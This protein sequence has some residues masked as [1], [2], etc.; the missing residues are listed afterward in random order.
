MVEVE[1]KLVE[2]Y[3]ASGKVR[4]VARHLL[5]LGENSRLA[6][7]ASECAGDQG[8]FWEM[9]AAIYERQNDLYT[10]NDMRGALQFIAG[11]VGADRQAV[12]ACLEAG[13]HRAAVE[14]DFRAAQEDGIRSRPVFD[15][16]DERIVGGREFADLQAIIDA[17]LP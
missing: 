6:A 11:E 2:A 7:E 12:A 5:Q 10:T 1:P 15:I 14:A 3:V 9:R 16:N 13:T 8:L 17:K 4:I